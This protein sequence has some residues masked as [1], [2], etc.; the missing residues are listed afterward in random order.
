MTAVH[1][2]ATGALPAELQAELDVFT[3]TMARCAACTAQLA[4]ATEPRVHT[5][6]GAAAVLA[7]ATACC[8]ALCRSGHRRGPRWRVVP[9]LLQFLRAPAADAAQGVRQGRAVCLANA[10]AARV[11]DEESVRVP[12]EATDVADVAARVR[13]VMKVRVLVACGA[14]TV[15]VSHG[16]CSGQ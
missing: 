11:A 15:L 10:S 16:C 7:A 5:A 13:E 2:V 4:E 12:V 9:E 6:K 3:V 1:D 14:L 8:S